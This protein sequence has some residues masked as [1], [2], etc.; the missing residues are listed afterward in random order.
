MG[1][2]TGLAEKM[3]TFPPLTGQL[4]MR[5]PADEHDT[6]TPTR[7]AARTRGWSAA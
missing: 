6:S 2:A 1:D 3:L 7:S 4:V 5:L